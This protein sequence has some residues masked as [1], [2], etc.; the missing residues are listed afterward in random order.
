MPHSRIAEFHAAPRRHAAIFD[1]PVMHRIMAAEMSA[2]TRPSVHCG[3][4]G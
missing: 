3:K 1:L 2:K 4:L